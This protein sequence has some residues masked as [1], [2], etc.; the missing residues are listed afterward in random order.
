MANFT[1][2]TLFLWQNE[3]AVVIGRFQNPWLETDSA[4]LRNHNVKL[5]RRVS[6]GGTVYHDQGKS[7]FSFK[8][9]FAEE[10]KKS[11]FFRLQVY[12]SNFE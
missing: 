6:G 8:E 11:V 12:S 9:F 7:A 10:I 5:A 3:P 2:N 1:R 4:Q